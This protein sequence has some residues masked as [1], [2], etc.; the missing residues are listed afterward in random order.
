MIKIVDNQKKIA[1]KVSKKIRC[2]NLQ[3]RALR[4]GYGTD[5]LGNVDNA[6]DGDH[7]KRKRRKVIVLQQKRGTSLDLTL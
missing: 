1:V 6:D 4:Q 7:T 3:S 2:S 5:A